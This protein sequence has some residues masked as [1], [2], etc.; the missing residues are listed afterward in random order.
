MGN[1]ASSFNSILKP[2][3]PSKL[4]FIG[5]DAAGKTTI[6]YH[7]AHNKVEN[8]VPVIGFNV[9]AVNFQGW[10]VT[11]WDVGGR[12]SMRPLWRHLAKD[13]DG[14]VF[15]VDASDLHRLDQARDELH[16]GINT[17]DCDGKGLPLLVYANKID[18]PNALQ[19]EELHD[20]LEIGR[21]KP[22][23]QCKLVPCI[24]TTGKGLHEGL[25]W[26][27]DTIS[28]GENNAAIGVEKKVEVQAPNK[29]HVLRSSIASSIGF[30]PVKNN[31]TLQSFLPI[32]NGTECPFAKAAKLWGGSDG[33][34]GGSDTVAANARALSEFVR[35]SNAGEN[36]DGFCIELPSDEGDPPEAFGQRVRQTLTSLSDC[37][38]EGENMMRK[39]Y[40][41]SRGWRYMYAGSDFFVTSFAPCYPPTSSRYSFGIKDRGFILLQ[42]E[43]SFLRHKIPNDTPVTMDPPQ[44]IRDKTRL[45]FR[46]AGRSYHIPPT[47]Q[48]PPAE[49]IVKPLKD[50]GT[51]VIYWWLEKSNNTIGNMAFEEEKKEVE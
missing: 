34:W 22:M 43:L 35:R 42:P 14:I 30:D 11:A 4:V 33:T 16:R 13:A 51:T 7:L 41:G 28:N 9:E 36:L 48:Y 37:D 31:A 47:T 46:D 38:P 12:S 21:L 15:V 45:S 5:L 10:A 20:R 3:K 49:H 19:L 29:Q 24:A 2:T 40:V 8:T 26:L 18:L 1:T 44:T 23:H 17:I 39:N 25:Q 50:D 32:K 27:C 6:L